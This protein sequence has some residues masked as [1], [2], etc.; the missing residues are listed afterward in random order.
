MDSLSHV[1]I[2]F[3][4]QRYIPLR[5]LLHRLIKIPYTRMMRITQNLVLKAKGMI[6]RC[7]TF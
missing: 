7:F 5:L 4:E 2:S 1:L 6:L 3:L